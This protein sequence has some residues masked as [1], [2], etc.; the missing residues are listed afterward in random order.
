MEKALQVSWVVLGTCGPGWDRKWDLKKNDVTRHSQPRLREGN[1]KPRLLGGDTCPSVNVEGQ[2][3]PRWAVAQGLR[4]GP[5]KT[6]ASRPLNLVPS[7]R[8]L[9]LQVCRRL[10]KQLSAH[11]EQDESD[12]PFPDSGGTNRPL[13]S[14]ARLSE[15]EG[16]VGE[17]GGEPNF[18]LQAT[19]PQR[20]PPG[21][22]E[23]WQGGTL[24]LEAP[25]VR[26]ASLS[27]GRG[28]G[29]GRV[30]RA[31]HSQEQFEGIPACACG[32]HLRAPGGG[33]GVQGWWPR[34]PS[35]SCPPKAS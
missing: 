32:G 30:H 18:A 22:P 26:K 19:R 17:G 11:T 2:A 9:W 16:G 29:P 34:P 6:W 35:C 8:C 23:A 21:L 33:G 5:T 25:P 27:G 12:A 10:W 20:D 4:P 31:P 14:P 3:G 7:L 13:C 1:T 15:G 28:V 24:G